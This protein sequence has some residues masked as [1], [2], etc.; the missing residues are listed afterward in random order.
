MENLAKKDEKKIVSA[1]VNDG[2][3][4]MYVRIDPVVKEQCEQ[5]AKKHRRSLASYV[6][7]VLRSGL[8]HDKQI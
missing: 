5:M 6:E 8:L 2:L 1:P 3:V 7:L 4:A